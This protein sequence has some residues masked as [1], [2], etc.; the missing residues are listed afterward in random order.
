[1]PDRLTQGLKWLARQRAAHM[2]SRVEYARGASSAPVAGASHGRTTAQVDDG[3]GGTVAVEVDD[4][5][6]PAAALV[7]D[8]LPTF[9]QRGDRITDADGFVYEVQALGSE[10][11]WRWCDGARVDIRV[12]TKLIERPQS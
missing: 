11:C 9:P 2:G 1:M 10:D 3:R 6:L 8:G 4:W 5:I 7:L 12:H